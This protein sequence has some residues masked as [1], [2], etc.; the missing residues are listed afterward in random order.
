MYVTIRDNVSTWSYKI[1]MTTYL[2]WYQ[3]CIKYFSTC[4]KKEQEERRFSTCNSFLKARSIETSLSSTQTLNPF[5]IILTALQSSNVLLIPLKL[6]KYTTI[7]SSAS[8]N[9]NNI[10]ASSFSGPERGF[11]P[12]FEAAR[13]SEEGFKF[14]DDDDNSFVVV[15]VVVGDSNK[16][17]SFFTILPRRDDFIDS[18]EP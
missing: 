2:S 18:I 9:R 14:D 13:G 16:V 6:V 15:V 3:T 4:H 8:A 10:P 1:T 12:N 11:W 17:Q 7:R 5:K